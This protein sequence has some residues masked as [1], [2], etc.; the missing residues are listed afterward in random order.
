LPAFGFSPRRTYL[1]V[2]GLRDVPHEADRETMPVNVG[3]T[4]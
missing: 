2:A 1:D 3:G 4:A